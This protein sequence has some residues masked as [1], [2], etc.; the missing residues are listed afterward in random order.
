MTSPLNPFDVAMLPLSE[1]VELKELL[2]EASKRVDTMRCD[3]QANG[4][5]DLIFDASGDACR[6]LN[7][8]L[9]VL[10]KIVWEIQAILI[11]ENKRFQDRS[12]S[13]L[14]VGE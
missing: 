1:L 11:L 6:A 7:A 13:R 14:G 10:Q 8:D 12:L 5:S 4:A 3:A 9:Q 2:G